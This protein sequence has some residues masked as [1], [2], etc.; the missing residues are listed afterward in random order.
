MKAH[1]CVVMVKAPRAGAVK[2]RLA[3]P[4]TREE[5]ASLAA[6]LARDTVASVRRVVSEVIIAY[7]PDD[8]RAVLEDIFKDEGLRWFAQCGEDLGARIE[9][10]ASHAFGLGL[11][12]VVIVG[13]DS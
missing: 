2:T 1:V 11:G 8:G 3:P 6:S 5:A 4:L 9:S 12:P 10:A 13:T 7:A